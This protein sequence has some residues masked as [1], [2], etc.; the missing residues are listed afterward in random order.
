MSSGNFSSSSSVV[1]IDGEE[2]RGWDPGSLSRYPSRSTLI[3]SQP[4]SSCC[5]SP[6]R[7]PCPCICTHTSTHAHTHATQWTSACCRDSRTGHCP[8]DSASQ[9][10]KP[11]L[12]PP[13]CFLPHPWRLGCRGA[14]RTSNLRPNCSPCLLPL[15]SSLPQSAQC[16]MGVL[17][18]FSPSGKPSQDRTVRQTGPI[19]EAQTFRGGGHG[20]HLEVVQVTGTIWHNFNWDAP[21]GKSATD[22]TRG[23]C[24]RTAETTGQSCELS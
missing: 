15:L 1:A 8:G 12:F 23:Q 13:P 7:S 14:G 9:A 6:I 10:L 22:G 3:G 18:I 17:S 20:R 5:S 2:Q 11:H 24:F 16:Q 21:V 4:G 19:P